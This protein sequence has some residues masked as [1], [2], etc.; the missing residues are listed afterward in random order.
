MA[1]I[2]Q[3]D[4]EDL[5]YE[6]PPVCMVCGKDATTYHRKKFSWNPA[7]CIS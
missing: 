1:T 2:T 6:L 4:P 3:Y 7:G 5:E